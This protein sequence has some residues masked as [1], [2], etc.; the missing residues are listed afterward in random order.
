MY[1]DACTFSCK[2]HYYCAILTKIGINGEIFTKYPNTKFH[3][4][5]FSCHVLHANRYDKANVPISASFHCEH[6]HTHTHKCIIPS[7]SA[8]KSPFCLKDSRFQH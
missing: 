8:K 1:K 5:P 3:E 4:N 6:I 7:L 2:D